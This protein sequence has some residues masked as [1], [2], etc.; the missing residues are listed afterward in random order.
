M[1]NTVMDDDNAH[2]ADKHKE[3]VTKNNGFGVNTLKKVTSGAYKKQLQEV[4]NIDNWNIGFYNDHILNT[5]ILVKAKSSN[6]LAADAGTEARKAALNT[7]IQ[8]QIQISLGK[9]NQVAS[10]DGKNTQAIIDLL[11]L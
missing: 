1:V 11:K 9:F 5:N 10:L 3:V 4:A 8:D 7:E 6:Q 2:L